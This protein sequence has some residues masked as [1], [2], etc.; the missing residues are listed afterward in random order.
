MQETVRDVML[1]LA[2]YVVAAEGQADRLAPTIISH[3]ERGDMARA[4][5]LAHIVRGYRIGA[6]EA[7]A[8]LC[9]LAGQG[10]AAPPA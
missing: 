7:R 1:G 5:E 3:R 2:A 4:D 9:A 8:N 6:L 10:R